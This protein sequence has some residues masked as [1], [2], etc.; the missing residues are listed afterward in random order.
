M[1]QDRPLLGVLLMLGFCALAPF[2]DSLAKLLGGRLPVID[3]AVLRFAAQALLILPIMAATGRNLRFPAAIWG[4][5]ALRTILHVA[6]L[7]LIFLALRFLPIADAIA[8]AYVMPFLM[9]ALGYVV[10]NE[11][12]GPHRLA[13]C[14]VGFAGTLL[15]VQPNFAEV[16]A[17]A[18]LPLGVAVIF[19]LFQLITR[20][21]A[22][23]VD[24]I[25]LQGAG[26]LLAMPVLLPVALLDGQPFPALDATGWGL[27]A[28]LGV[29]GTLA[30][31]LMTWSLRFAPAATLAPMQY[32]E[33]PVATVY[34]LVIFDDL[35][36]GLAAIG[37]AVTMA[38]GLYIVAR[39][40]RISRAIPR[41]PTAPPAPPSAG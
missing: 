17:P 4:L 20:Q 27:V 32:I 40:R 13:A 29:T 38:A 34:G 2:A 24:A 36:N 28:V 33:I 14:T 16:G 26:G 37:I 1:P 39:E 35:P 21:L 9:L 41:P 30:H 7:V 8:I 15:V 19:A 31:L 18:L 6:G 25:T 10:L 22:Q 3:L 23:K 11:Q 12:V 5:I